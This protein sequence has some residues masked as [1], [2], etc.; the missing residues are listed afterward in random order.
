MFTRQ[1][2][3]MYQEKKFFKKNKLSRDRTQNKQQTNGTKSIKVT[4]M[5]YLYILNSVIR[6]IV[7][8]ANDVTRL[9]YNLWVIRW[10]FFRTM[11]RNTSTA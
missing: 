1:N 3:Y 5:F 6:T 11:F 7:R 2:N 8:T 4:P 9:P 10:I